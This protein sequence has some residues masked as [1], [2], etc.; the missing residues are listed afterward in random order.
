MPDLRPQDSFGPYQILRELGRGGMGVVYLARHNLLK[1]LVALKLIKAELSGPTG[2]VAR[3]RREAEAVARLQHPNIVQIF[4]VG[5]IDG[6]PFL[7]L[8]YVEG[9]T[10]A[11]KLDGTPWPGRDAAAPLEP[12]AWA[13]DA[14]HRAGIVHRDLKPSNILLASGGVPKI[15]DFG[16]A[17]ILESSQQTASGDFV[18]T[19]SYCAPEQAAGQQRQ[20]GPRTDVYALGA[21]LYEL[22]TGRPPFR[23]ATLMETLGQVIHQ[24][25]ASVRVLNPSVN[26]DLETICLKCLE[27]NPERRY[28]T[29][30][31]L[32]DDLRRF[33]EH[34]PIH[35]RPISSFGRLRRWAQRNRG[36]AA[37]LALLGLFLTVAAVGSALAAG[38]FRELAENET[39][40]RFQAQS[41]EQKEAQQRQQAETARE[42][43][44]RMLYFSQIDAALRLADSPSGIER[45]RELVDV[46]LPQPGQ[47]DLRGWEWDV[48]RAASRCE[49]RV[50]DLQE[51]LGVVAWG[52]EGKRLAVRA[53]EGVVLID[54]DAGSVAAEWGAA[55]LFTDLI[56]WSPDGTRLAACSDETLVVVDGTS[57]KVMHNHQTQ[58]SVVRIS[59]HPDG[60]RLAYYGN[61]Q[62]I[63]V[64]DFATGADAVV[65]RDIKERAPAGFGYSPDGK[66]LA[67]CGR[68][69]GYP[70]YGLRVWEA[71]S[72]KEVHLFHGLDAE[73]TAV[74][75]GRDGRRVAAA[76]AGGEIRVW[77]VATGQQVSA[78]P[79]DGHFTP[80]LAW[81]PD[82]QRLA[83]GNWNHQIRIWNPDANQE[84][85]LLR[86]HTDR[87][88]GLAW[89]PDSRRL[90][91]TGSD[92]LVRIWDVARTLPVWSRDLHHRGVRPT[93][94]S[95]AWKHNGMRLAVSYQNLGTTIWDRRSGEK[96]Q[97]V[98]GV[99]ACWSHDDRFFASIF[100]EAVTIWNTT[101][102]KPLHTREIRGQ[103]KQLA[104]NPRDNRLAIRGGDRFWVWDV[105]S[106]T[107]PVR[108][109]GEPLP[110]K[111]IPLEFDGAIAWSRDGRRLAL[112]YRD[113]QDWV[114]AL[115]D[116]AG[117]T[118]PRELAR[119]GR[120]STRSPGPRTTAAWQRREPT[121]RFT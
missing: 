113:D 32:A 11:Q 75:W 5:D 17:K 72:W 64:C 86:G 46:W 83:W 91:S 1:R 47:K 9:G 87:V 56:Q 8:E 71:E 42:Q 65:L 69:P 121:P 10:L 55:G 45:L 26:R 31:D 18:G 12:L 53:R 40:L 52:P 74:A 27:K 29:A 94:V 39:R 70:D 66:Y 110:E 24:E 7:A 23:G 38:Y 89:S 49:E 102:T 67:S 6:R 81:S 90:V 2:D 30:G 43:M 105:G 4:E 58:V 97:E 115:W 106:D 15:A 120:R 14:A 78:Q 84:P 54:P 62:A 44:R 57:G 77:D 101:I 22:Q 63:H 112:A 88:R 109:Q 117:S 107:P 36:L 82:G 19:P 100:G 16:L 51:S 25:P 80:V 3:F 79:P 41:A 111:S 60:R 21:I 61:D 37:A 85:E 98:R 108:I 119:S 20:V 73:V 13:I 34:R 92:G 93:Y 35:A 28:A 68:G 76:T 114:I 33:L 99:C 118:P 104:W 96:V 103:S 48:A 95:T 50:L 59:W 116:A